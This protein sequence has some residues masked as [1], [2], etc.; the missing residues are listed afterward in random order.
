FNNFNINVNA[1]TANHADP[2][3]GSGRGNGF[4]LTPHPNPP[5]LVFPPPNPGQA[6]FGEEP[7][8][9]PIPNGGCVLQPINFLVSGNPFATNGPG[10]FGHFID[11]FNGPAPPPASPPPPTPPCAFAVR[12]QIGHFLYILD[13]DND[14]ILIVNSNRLTVLDSIR[15]RDPVNMAMSVNVR[16]LAVTNFSSASVSWIDID[17]TSK[18]FHQV[19]GETRTQPGPG[20]IAWQGDGEDVLVVHPLGNRL[21]I[22]T[23]NDQQ[24]RKTITGFLN[25]PLAVTTTERFLGFGA[26]TS[27]YYAYIL[28]RNGT[29][30]VYESG[31]DGVNGIGFDDIIGTVPNVVFPSPRKMSAILATQMGGIFVSHTDDRGNGQ[32]SKLELVNTPGTQPIQQQQ[33]GFILP[34]TFRQ[35]EWKVTQTYGGNDP[36]NVGKD[37]LSGRA[38]HEI[39]TDEMFNFAGL[40]GQPTVWNTG[41]PTPPMLHSG[42]HMVKVLP[43]GARIVPATPKFLFIS[44]VDKGVI[45]VFDIGTARRVFTINVGGTPAVLAGYWRQ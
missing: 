38:P 39:M 10:L 16:T 12:Q 27:V 6:I 33:G 18:T 31:P 19:V 34:P 20:N 36:T 28:N 3:G 32:V 4:T 13:A 22:I 23:A 11:I 30:T 14:Q 44:L 42:K 40:P 5:K 26:A 45:D 25:Q 9:T 24:V 43:S 7:T 29:V 2:L 17:P 37:Q 35:L 21:T 8:A 15:L 41:I 1:A